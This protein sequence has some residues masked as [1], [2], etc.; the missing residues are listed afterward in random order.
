MFEKLGKNL[1]VEL[2]ERKIGENWSVELLE[3]LPN[4]RPSLFHLPRIRPPKVY[5]FH[6]EMWQISTSIL[7]FMFKCQPTDFFF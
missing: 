4:V 5:Q 1:S 3:R 2:L 7:N 6:Q